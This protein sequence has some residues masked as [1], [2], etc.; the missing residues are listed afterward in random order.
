MTAPDANNQVRRDRNATVDVGDA[1]AVEKTTYASNAHGAEPGDAPAQNQRVTATVESGRGL[2][3]LG[4]I[5]LVLG[6]L[7][8]VAY[9]LG[10]FT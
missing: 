1:D 8:L 5:A 7:A 3:P 10:L 4:W 9:A 6:A 2:G